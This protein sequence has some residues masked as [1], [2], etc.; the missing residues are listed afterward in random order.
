MKLGEQVAL[1]TG[2]EISRLSLGTAALGATLHIS[3]RCRLL[4]YSVGNSLQ[5]RNSH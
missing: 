5:F 2:V 1:P 4:R 3:Q